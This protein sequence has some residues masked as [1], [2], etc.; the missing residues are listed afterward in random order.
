MEDLEEP[1]E[2]RHF[3][4]LPTALSTATVDKG[5]F[6]VVEPRQRPT[7]PEVVC[8]ANHQAHIYFWPPPFTDKG[9]FIV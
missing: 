8:P 5:K 4:L 1:R 2:D 3:H 7:E 6:A 9:G